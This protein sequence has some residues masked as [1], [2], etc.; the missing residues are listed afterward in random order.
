MNKSLRPF[1]SAGFVASGLCCCCLLVV[2]GIVVAANQA[3]VATAVAGQ[4]G[5]NIA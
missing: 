4:S 2:S 3:G 1:R 5:S